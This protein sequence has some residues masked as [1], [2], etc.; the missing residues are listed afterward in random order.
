[1]A[2]NPAPPKE[3]IFVPV[4]NGTSAAAAAAAANSAPAPAPAPTP[5]PDESQ[6]NSQA[7]ASTPGLLEPA[8]AAQLREAREK[9]HP[10]IGR[11]YPD[12]DA[13]HAALE[14]EAKARGYALC[15][16]SKRPNPTEPRRVIYACSKAG[17]HR[18]SRREAET[19]APA[20]KRR[21]TTSTKTD[22]QYKIALKRH[23]SGRWFVEPVNASQ[24]GVHNHPMMGIGAY[25]RYRMEILL[26]RKADILHAIG[27]GAKPME[28]LKDLRHDDPEFEHVTRSD[29]MNMLASAAGATGGGGGREGEGKGEDEN[30]QAEVDTGAEQASPSA[31]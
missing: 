2:T 13:A 9:Y 22:C 1:M 25:P 14:G 3:P 4:N 28:I 7:A 12:L 27:K 19:D 5:T 16:H 23:W 18:D 21:K 6:P 11:V 17:K 29:V 31:E 15:I 26:R 20:V 10:F 30:G 24:G 8:Y